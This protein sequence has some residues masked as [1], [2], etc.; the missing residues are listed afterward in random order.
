[1]EHKTPYPIKI[2]RKTAKSRLLGILCFVLGGIFGITVAVISL[3][4]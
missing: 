1:M 2:S 4:S 3:A